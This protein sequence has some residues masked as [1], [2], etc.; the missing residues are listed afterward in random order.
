MLFMM[1]YDD[2]E[3]TMRIYYDAVNYYEVTDSA[4]HTTNGASVALH[5]MS[6]SRYTLGDDNTRLYAFSAG[7]GL[8]TETQAAEMAAV[9]KAR[10]GRD[11]VPSGN[12]CTGK[13]SDCIDDVFME[14]LAN[15]SDSYSGSGSTWAN[16]AVNPSDGA[17]QT[18]YDATITGLTFTGTAGTAGAYF[19][20][21]GSSYASFPLS[22]DQPALYTG[23]DYNSPNYAR[24]FCGIA[25]RTPSDLTDDPY[26]FGNVDHEG[27]DSGSVETGFGLRYRDAATDEIYGEVF[28][29]AK[30]ESHSQTQTLSASTDYA[31]IYQHVPYDSEDSNTDSQAFYINSMT[32]IGGIS[33]DFSSNGDATD[34][35]EA[36]GDWV[37]GG[38]YAESAGDVTRLMG[39]GGRIYSHFC[40]QARPTPANIKNALIAM[41]NNA[42]IDFDGDSTVG[43]VTN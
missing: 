41:E 31:I 34:Q 15:N 3:D 18:D 26:F 6:D 36:T 1:S 7:Q 22:A 38:T 12:D 27:A 35:D 37:I 25:L 17:D 10:H 19:A 8:L 11:Y 20:T 5:I 13:F 30:E 21:D 43:S 2:S 28:Y 40:T 32:A 23:V 33:N 39:S 9:Y 16:V 14:F 24:M 42:N 4:G 29:I